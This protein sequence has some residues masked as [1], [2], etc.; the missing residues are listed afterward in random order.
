VKVDPGQ[1]EQ[2][3]MNLVV[4]ARDAMPRGGR[5]TIET[6]RITIDEQDVPGRPGGRAGDFVR[7]SVADTGVGISEEIKARLFE[8]FF[9]TKG[10][11]QGT[12]M[13]LAT[14]FGIAQQ[15]GGWVEVESEPQT[16]AVFRVYWP[17]PVEQQPTSVLPRAHISVPRGRETVLVVEDEGGVRGLVCRI[18][19]GGGYE[20]LE[21]CGGGEALAL[22]SQESRP[23][24]LLISD[25]VMP[26][27]S[28]PELVQRVAEY[29]ADLKVLYISGYVD[30]EQIPREL[31]DSGV[32]L[33]QKPFSPQELLRAVRELLDAGTGA[34]QSRDQARTL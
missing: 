28:G 32:P 19:R 8:P 2:V 20:V 34:S 33:L 5:L 6:E 12:G 7:L 13:G 30:T 14:V 4:N 9:T 10:P 15:N 29:Q 25:L 18:L 23:I 26:H 31:I 17:L 1:L 27:I 16:G 11:G 21:A 24:Q 22:C 3:L